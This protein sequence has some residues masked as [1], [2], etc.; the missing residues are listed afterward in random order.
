MPRDSVE[1]LGPKVVDYGFTMPVPRSR[2]QCSGPRT[3]RLRQAS[4][5]RT[6]LHA[7]SLN[8]RAGLRPLTYMARRAKKEG[9][10]L[11][12]TKGSARDPD[13]RLGSQPP[14]GSSRMKRV[15][16]CECTRSTLS[17]AISPMQVTIASVSRSPRF[18]PGALPDS[19]LA[20][21][22]PVPGPRACPAHR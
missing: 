18:A 2:M 8:F 7:N 13:R 1:P 20:L 17:P 19:P 10:P 5:I 21:P 14:A 6:V 9:A 4:D 22:G 15:P 3:S 16:G 12:S 11:S